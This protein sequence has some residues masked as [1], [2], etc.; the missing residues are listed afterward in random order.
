MHYNWLLTTI[1]QSSAA[2]VG[3]SSGFLILRISMYVNQKI[4]L[5]NIK[6]QSELIKAEQTSGLFGRRLE[7]LT[8]EGKVDLREIS[9]PYTVLI[10]LIGIPWLIVVLGQSVNQL[11]KF[12]VD[13]SDV[14]CIKFSF[15]GGLFILAFYLI[16]EV[17]YVALFKFRNKENNNESQ[18]KK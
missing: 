13:S 5:K 17:F 4:N 2:L 1:A 9:F 8:E 7:N 11:S 14:Q 10:G 3:I 16:V 12:I 18:N 15:F 6:S